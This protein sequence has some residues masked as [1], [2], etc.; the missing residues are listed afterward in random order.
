MD[1]EAVNLTMIVVILVGVID[2]KNI[3]KQLIHL[4]VTVENVMIMMIGNVRSV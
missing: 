3:K 2:L 4:D 1:V